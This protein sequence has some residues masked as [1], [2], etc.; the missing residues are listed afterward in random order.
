MLYQRHHMSAT[1]AASDVE[2]GE[3]QTPQR[4]ASTRI[5]SAPTILLRTDT[6][7]RAL[8]SLC[9]VDLVRLFGCPG[10]GQ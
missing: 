9:L 5:I 4:E 7:R 6:L 8:T 3:R 2:A 10:L 1:V